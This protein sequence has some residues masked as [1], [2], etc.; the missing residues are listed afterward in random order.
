MR[1]E[2]RKMV[3]MD[4]CAGQ[5]WRHKHSKQTCELIVVHGF[6]L[7]AVPV[8]GV[9]FLFWASLSFCCRLDCR[10]C[11]PF[12][13]N[14]SIVSTKGSG[15]RLPKAQ[16]CACFP[17]WALSRC[18]RSCDSKHAAHVAFLSH[19]SICLEIPSSRFMPASC[20]TS[21]RIQEWDAWSRS[22]DGHKLD[23]KFK[24]QLPSQAQSRSAPPDLR[25]RSKPSWDQQVHSHLTLKNK[26]LLHHQD[27]GL[28]LRNGWNVLHISL[29]HVCLGHCFANF[30]MLYT[31]LT[32]Q[33]VNP[34][35]SS[36]FP[37]CETFCPTTKFILYT[38]PGLGTKGEQ[39]A[40][41]L[42]E[43]TGNNSGYREMA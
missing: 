24:A 33:L 37:P 26:L 40:L 6:Y 43:E 39:T 38:D 19:L 36:S 28:F 42:A 20:I 25:M 4:L 15:F 2:S 18:D 10:M 21:A 23:L 35:F 30:Q 32:R 14:L 11:H 1:V 16:A 22:E 7:C 12:L 27:W 3:L 8:T 5:P 31:W 17:Q 9:W 41:R 34:F 29:A 13:W